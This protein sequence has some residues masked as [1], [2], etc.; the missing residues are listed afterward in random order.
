MHPGKV[1]ARLNAK[2]ARFDIGSGS[3]TDLTQ[4]DIAGALAFVPAGMGR[5]LLC[6]VWWPD[7]SRLAASALDHL[8]LHAQLGEHGRREE[9][10]YR[11][12]AAVACKA[13]GD[14]SRYSEL[15]YAE[16]HARR[17]PQWVTRMEPLTVTQGYAL[18]RAA[19][20]EEL[21]SPKVCPDC[22]GRA[23]RLVDKLVQKCARCSGTG[24]V[25]FGPTWRAKHLGMKEPS[26]KQTWERPYEWLL[27]LASVALRSAE[28]DL[29]AAL[30]D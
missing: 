4:Q 5:E 7:G 3:K 28:H 9:S 29:L 2:N 26:Y 8:L 11:A 19:V 1:M 24:H 25:C 6:R 16:A 12:L 13:K 30:A 20:V 22:T 10:M 23:E 15:K 21:S 27:D 17:W 18:I 14:S